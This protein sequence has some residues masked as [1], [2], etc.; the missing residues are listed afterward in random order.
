MQHVIAASDRRVPATI[1]VQVGNDHGEAIAVGGTGRR[2][3]ALLFGQ[4]ADCGTH[5]ITALQQVHDAP[6]G[7]EP[8]STSYQH[9]LRHNRTPHCTS[10]QL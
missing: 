1:V 5:G 9:C 4:I 2:A 7:D 6:P 10:L 8:A 3:D